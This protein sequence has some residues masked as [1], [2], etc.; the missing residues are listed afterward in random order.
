M[1]TEIEMEA[2]QLDLATEME[3]EIE[4][5]QLD[6]VT[7]TEIE[8]GQLDLV[9]P[10]VLAREIGRTSQWKNQLKKYTRE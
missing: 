7:E 2:G 1:V 6:L 5:G 8:I 9:H 4:A 10:M 3:I